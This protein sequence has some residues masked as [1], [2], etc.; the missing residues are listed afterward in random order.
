V[1]D[2]LALAELQLNKRNIK[3]TTELGSDVSPV[4]GDPIKLQ[5][6]LM[7]LLLNARDAMPTGGELRIQTTQ[8]NG[9]SMLRVTDTGT[10]IK[11]TDLNKV[12]D[13]FFTTKGIGKGT[14]L[15]LSVSYG[16]IQEHRGTIAVE[17]DPDT[18]TTFRI[19]LPSTS[20]DEHAA[21]I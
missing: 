10:G 19:T 17:S 15:G 14:G 6:V 20:I 1:H 18:G 7:N 11:E 16:I 3:I 9:D 8:S 5:Q 21:A 2:T 4:T 12:Y 13:P